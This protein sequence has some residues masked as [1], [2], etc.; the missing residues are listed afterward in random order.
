MAGRTLL[1]QAL[2][3]TFGLKAAGWLVAPGRG[4]GRPRAGPAET[5]WPCSSAAPPAR[6]P[7]SAPTA[8]RWLEHL[9]DRLG[10]AEPVLP[11]HTNRARVAELAGA[12]VGRGRG[13]GKVA[14]DVTLLA[15]TEVG[16]VAEAA[17]PG[18]GGSSAMPHKRNPV[19]AV[20][21]VA[22]RPPGRRGWSP[23]CSAR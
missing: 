17:G 21:V 18:R 19:G 14:P 23:P 1:Q 12:L 11:W 4:R 5:G 8:P 15:Q 22:G 6:W 2:P 3:I 10:L 13:P 20:L 16:E 9:A 7:P